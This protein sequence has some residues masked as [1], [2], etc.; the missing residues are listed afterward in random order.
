MTIILAVPLIGLMGTCLSYAADLIV[1]VTKIVMINIGKRKNKRKSVKICSKKVCMAQFVLMLISWSFLSIAC[2]LN[3][4]MKP[5]D[6]M[7]F[8][9]VTLTTVGF[10]DFTFPSRKAPVKYIINCLFLHLSMATVA[11]FVASI[12]EIVKNLKFKKL[13]SQ[14]RK[15]VSQVE[16]KIETIITY[17]NPNAKND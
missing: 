13:G 17:V 14:I 1:T 4:R 5:L 8:V 12:V 9:C 6:A 11:S 15:K 10:G 3:S 2:M 16:E 7:Y